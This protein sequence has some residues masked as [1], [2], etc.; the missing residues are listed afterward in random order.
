[1]LS[2][3]IVSAQIGGR[4]IWT[5]PATFV[6]TMAVGAVLGILGVALPVVEYGITGSVLVL[7]LAILFGRSIPERVALVQ[8]DGELCRDRTTQFF[9]DREPGVHRFTGQRIF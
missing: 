3:G 4:A 9:A 6:G 1:M 7:G 8:L 2:V 5:V